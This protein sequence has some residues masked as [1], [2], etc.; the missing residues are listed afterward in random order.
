MPEHSLA[1]SDFY[2]LGAMLNSVLTNNRVITVIEQEVV[3]KCPFF[4]GA[5]LGRLLYG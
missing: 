4:N 2:R 5:S 1:L 3:S